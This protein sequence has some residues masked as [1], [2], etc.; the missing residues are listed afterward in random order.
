MIRIHR[1]SKVSGDKKKWKQDEKNVK[2]IGFITK[3][4]Q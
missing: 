4:R 1:E 3:K 2:K